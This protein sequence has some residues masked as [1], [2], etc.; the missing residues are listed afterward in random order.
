LRVTP[1]AG[2]TQ[3]AV[4][5]GPVT[6]TVGTGVMP[7]GDWQKQGLAA[8]S[9]GIRYRRTISVEPPRV[10]TRAVLDLGEVRG[11]A[12]VAV[13]GQPVGARVWSPCQFEIGSCLRAGPNRIEVTVFN[14][15]APYLDTVSPTPFVLPGQK[16]SGRFGPVQIVWPH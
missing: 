3:G 14:T 7:C 5:A 8:Y 11:T 12:E 4:F 16:R 9:G 2:R 1:Q 15:L 13:N 10:G 6:F